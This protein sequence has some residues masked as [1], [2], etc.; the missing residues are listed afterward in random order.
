MAYLRRSDWR[1]NVIFKH[2]LTVQVLSTFVRTDKTSR[3]ESV[4]KQVLGQSLYTPATYTWHYIK[5]FK[6]VV[7]VRIY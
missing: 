1:R 5:Y 6:C 4:Q 3:K 2:L 7:F